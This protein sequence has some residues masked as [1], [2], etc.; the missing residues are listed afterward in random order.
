[1][2]GRSMAMMLKSG[3]S[4][5]LN[6]LWMQTEVLKREGLDV[7]FRWIAIPSDHP[8]DMT[9]PPFNQRITHALSDLGDELGRRPDPWQQVPPDP[10]SRGLQNPR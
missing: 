1:M 9:L 3:V 4:S 5:P 7:E 10:T 8:I 2:F 6:L